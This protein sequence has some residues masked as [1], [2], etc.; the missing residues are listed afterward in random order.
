MHSIQ[1]PSQTGSI[2]HLTFNEI[3]K[4]KKP[5]TTAVTKITNPFINQKHL[6][7]TRETVHH[8]IHTL[9]VCVCILDRINCNRH[10]KAIIKHVVLYFRILLCIDEKQISMMENTNCCVCALIIYNI[11]MLILVNVALC[12]GIYWRWYCM[13]PRSLPLLCYSIQSFDSQKMHLTANI[14]VV[15][16]EKTSGKWHLNE[17]HFD[18]IL[19]VDLPSQ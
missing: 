4:E 5:K 2:Y 15:C 13:M 18:R 19:N 7:S 1:H 10:E 11:Y 8:N 3:E 12:D 14:R 17:L 16:S 6:M 9:Y